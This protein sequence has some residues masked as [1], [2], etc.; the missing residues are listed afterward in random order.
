MV[1]YDFTVI[2]PN[3]PPSY[4]CTTESISSPGKILIGVCVTSR[5]SYFVVSYLSVSCREYITLVGEESAGALSF[6]SLLDR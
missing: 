3:V 2:W 6:Q 5:I 4:T 1:K